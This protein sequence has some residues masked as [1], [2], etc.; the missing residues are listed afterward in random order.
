[1]CRHHIALKLR[2]VLGRHFK[3][4]YSDEKKSLIRPHR[5]SGGGQLKRGLS[6]RH[7]WAWI[8]DVETGFL[9]QLSASRCLEALAGIDGTSEYTLDQTPLDP[10]SR[11]AVLW[12]F[13]HVAPKLRAGA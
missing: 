1:M 7:L 8:V 10:G 4:M 12:Q 11:R 2:P 3:I 6:P 5:F 13:R 9:K